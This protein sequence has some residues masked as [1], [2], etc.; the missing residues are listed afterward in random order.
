MAFPLVKIHFYLSHFQFFCIKM[1]NFVLHVQF[2]EDSNINRD[3]YIPNPQCRDFPRY[4]WIGQLMG[5]CMRGKE[6][7]VL[8]LPAFVWKKLVGER[9]SWDRDFVT[10]DAATVGAFIILILHH[11]VLFLHTK[12]VL[13]LLF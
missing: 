2:S 12:Q 13:T 7:L 3:M 6:N 11:F 5:A 8:A 1:T 4:E 9:I 10:V